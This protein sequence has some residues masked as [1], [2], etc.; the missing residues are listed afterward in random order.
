[1]GTHAYVT[2]NGS[3]NVSV[4]DTGSNTVTATVPVGTTPQGVAVT[5]DGTH[6]YVT[7]NGSNNVSVIDTGSN[8]VTATVP[9]ISLPAGVA[10]TSPRVVA[11]TISGTPAAGTV[12]AAY[13]FQFTLTGTPAPTATVSSGTLP[14]G[15]T[16]SSSGLLSGT[17]TQGGS[18]PLT[19]KAA[20]AAGSA[21]DTFTLVI[22]PAPTTLTAGAAT[23]RPLV[24][25]R[26]QITGLT[27]TLTSNG[28]PVAGRTV[29]F[30]TRNGGVALCTATTNAQGVATCNA[31][32]TQ[33]VVGNT[34]VNVGLLLRGYRAAYS[35]DTNHLA[36]APAYGTATLG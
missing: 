3:N 26:V 35:G 25:A 34:V 13:S 7:N 23:L 21:T 20:N 27:A 33:G 2:N 12:G 15:L 24:G 29:T 22:N 5:P 14:A 28:T 16:L 18:F 19:A 32:L 9:V 11:P 17:P 4:I 31:T 10:V 8:T 1:D 6:A 36:A 30:T